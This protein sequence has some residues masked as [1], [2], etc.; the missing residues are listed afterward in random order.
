M[1]ELGHDQLN[2]TKELLDIA[3]QHTS[4]EEAVGPSLFRASGKWSSV[5]AGQ[6]RTK[7]QALRKALRAAR[8]GKM[9]PR[10]VTVA[11]DGNDDDKEADDSDDEYVAVTEH[12]FKR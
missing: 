1:H 4:G 2:T 5:A 9:A 3:T 11:T 10:R 7:P 8:R 12:N 6:H